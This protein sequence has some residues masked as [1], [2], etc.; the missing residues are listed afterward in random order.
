MVA[1]SWR[2]EQAG[3]WSCACWDVDYAW[4]SLD[5]WMS[6]CNRSPPYFPR[7]ELDL[8][9]LGVVFYVYFPAL[10]LRE[11]LVQT[12]FF[13]LPLC[14]VALLSTLRFFPF[15]LSADIFSLYARGLYLWCSFPGKRK[16]LTSQPW[17]LTQTQYSISNY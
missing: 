9:M 8:C 7:R 10:R 12:P 13:L 15:S 3:F 17:P 6:V 2:L 1:R 5:S 14:K 16:V 4:N 11:Q